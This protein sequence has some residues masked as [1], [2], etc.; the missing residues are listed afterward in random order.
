MRA[1][2]IPFSII[3]YTSGRL[4]DCS[5]L[6]AELLMAARSGLQEGCL[7][8][9]TRFLGVLAQACAARGAEL[10]A[11]LHLASSLDGYTDSLVQY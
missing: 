1:F 3:L 9:C 2:N 10:K 4:E 8:L 6:L 7:R 11:G 5:G